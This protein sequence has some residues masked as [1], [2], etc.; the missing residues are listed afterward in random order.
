MR[1]YLVLT[2]TMLA[3]A[4]GTRDVSATD[5]HFLHG[6]GAINA[7]MGGAGVAA[8]RSLLGTFYLNPSGLLAFSGTRMEFGFELFKPHRSVTSD[9]TALGFGAGTTASN[10]EFSPI[11]AMALTNRVSNRIVVGVG[12]L[13]IGGFGVDYPDAENP[14]L[15]PQPY[16]Y[17]AVYS[18]YQFLKIAPAVAFAVTDR[19]WVGGAVNIDWASLAV[20]PFPIA[21]P[22]VDPGPDGTWGTADDRGYYSSAANSDGAFGAGFQL[23]VLAKVSDRVSIGA[24]Y[25]SPQ[26][27]EEFQYNGA[28]EDPNLPNYLAPR[29]LTFRLDAP[30]VYAAGVALTPARGLTLA[31]D[32]R[33]ITYASTNGFR[34]AGFNADGSVKGFGWR[35]IWVGSFGVDWEATGLLALRAG[36]NVTENPVPDSLSALNV[37]APAIVK[38]HLTLGAG[39]RLSPMLELSG[40]Y[41]HAFQ[42]GI[43]GSMLRPRGPVP[44]T[45][46]TNELS[47]DSFL[48][49]FTV[50][51]R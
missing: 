34:D 41:Y 44:G 38:H 4:I 24:S 37:P 47:E 43:T 15:V 5:G 12:A 9:A 13:G 17:G 29:S 39:L 21:A 46:V 36:Y 51:P 23:G 30:A 42:N 8:P 32:G 20:R 11:P 27:F 6:V 49:Q 14:V 33:Y 35:N 7:A 22:A 1:R 2:S 26:W 48:M 10:S 25:T 3:L 28:F 50:T 19:I 40:A 18:N 16:G 45:S 31:A